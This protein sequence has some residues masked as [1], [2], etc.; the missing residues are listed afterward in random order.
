MGKLTILEFKV[1]EMKKLL[2]FLWLALI[3]ASCSKKPIANFYWTPAVPKAGQEVV[4]TNLSTDATSFS[5]N[6][7]DM[8]IGS[9]RNPKH[10]YKSAGDY[11]IDLNASSGLRTDIMTATIRV[12]Q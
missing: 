6:F 5:W 1:S 4:F 9:S 3:F 7:G 10:V 2:V 8:S 11:I 12:E